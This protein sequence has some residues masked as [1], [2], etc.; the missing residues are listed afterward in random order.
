MNT[1]IF[2]VILFIVVTAVG[3]MMELSA[4]AS[5]REHKAEETI[6]HRLAKDVHDSKA[7]AFAYMATRCPARFLVDQEAK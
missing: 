2:L 1:T 5:S 3:A 6:C 4:K 7:T